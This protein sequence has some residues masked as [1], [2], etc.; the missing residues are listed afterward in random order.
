[1]TTNPHEGSKLTLSTGLAQED[2]KP[3]VVYYRTEVLLAQAETLGRLHRA[4]DKERKLLW[5]LLGQAAPPSVAHA[6]RAVAECAIADEISIGVVVVSRPVMLEIVEK[7]RPFRLEAMRL[8]I[9]QRK[10]EAVVDTDERGGVL[11]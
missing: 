5:T 1:V 11:G 8:E 6:R 2:L 10:R 3:E 4:A 7:N 9:A